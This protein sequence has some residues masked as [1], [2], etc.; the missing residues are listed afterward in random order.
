MEVFY[1]EIIHIIIII[2]NSN[3]ILALFKLYQISEESPTFSIQFLLFS[4]FIT[5]TRAVDSNMVVK[6]ICNYEKVLKFLARY[7]NISSQSI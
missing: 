3:T 6:Q 2:K 1:I 5:L 7:I 4:I